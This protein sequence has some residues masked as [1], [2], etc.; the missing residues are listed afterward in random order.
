MYSTT[1]H[2]QLFEPY[3]CCEPKNILKTNATSCPLAVV[4]LNSGTEDIYIQSDVDRVM[5]G[6]NLCD[7]GS[8]IMCI[9]CQNVHCLRYSWYSR[10]FGSRLYPSLQVIRCHY[11][12]KFVNSIPKFRNVVYGLPQ[13]DPTNLSRVIMSHEYDR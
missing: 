10:L 5:V 3:T 8:T 11:N 4:F 12:N 7:F 6:T 9:T 2:L 13:A 1:K